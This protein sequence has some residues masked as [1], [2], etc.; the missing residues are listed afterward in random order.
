[1][2]YGLKVL[3]GLSRGYSWFIK[4]NILVLYP[5]SIL[6]SENEEDFEGIRAE[7]RKETAVPNNSP[8]KDFLPFAVHQCVDDYAGFVIE[9]EKVTEKVIVVH[10]TWR[11]D[12]ELDSYPNITCYDSIWQWLELQVVG[13]LDLLEKVVQYQ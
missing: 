4:Q 8:V 13:D 7:F 2:I 6:T 11:G 3:E 5:W 1:M 10:L 9:N 12:V